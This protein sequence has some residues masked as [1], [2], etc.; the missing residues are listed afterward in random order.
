LTCHLRRDYTSQVLRIIGG[1]LGGRRLT[2]PPGAVT[3]PTA[4]RVREALFN[5]LGAPTAGA[6]VLDVFAGAG[7]LGLEALS[8][9]A[10]EAWFIERA[11]AALRCL[12]ANVAGLDLDAACHVVRGDAV[13][14]LRRWDATA[15]QRDLTGGADPGLRFG[16][17]FLDPPYQ[18]DLAARALAVLGE[19][20]L[21]APDARVV[22]EHDR[23]NPPE[24]RHGGLV[25][26]DLRRYGDT[27]LSLYRNESPPD[28]GPADLP[29]AVTMSQTTPTV[30]V[31]PGTF[32]PVTNGHIDI[33]E[34]SLML[35]DRVIV[36][37]ATN[38]RKQPLFSA[39]E[40]VDFIRSAL[41]DRDDKLAFDSF[42]GLLV[43]YCKRAGARFIVR[44]LR[45]LADFEY[46]FQFAHMNRRLAPGLDTVFF[47]T[48]ERNHYV[49]SSLVKEVASFGGDITGLVPARVAAALVAKFSPTQE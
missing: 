35:F 44:G 49:S 17:V 18:T 34:R 38:P 27:E 4:D 14:I 3:R 11:P 21:L 37:L 6:R 28:A 26:T 22:V 10:A 5:I 7:A 36:A 9:G 1:A 24:P 41:G 20:R 13:A 23:R 33:L 2:A 42:D 25:R 45:A 48:D 46:E 19:G 29:H 15:R 43:E 30:A 40:R 12:R 31:Y 32:D 8:R 39:E 16:W 47:M